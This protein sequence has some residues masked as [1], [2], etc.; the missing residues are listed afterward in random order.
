MKGKKS[1]F[2]V[3]SW[4][5]LVLGIFCGVALAGV[6]MK[7][8]PLIEENKIN[9]TRQLIPELL[10]GE[11]QARQAAAAG[12][13]LTS[14]QNMVPVDQGGGRTTS[15]NVFKATEADVVKGW[16]AKASGNGYAANIE[17]LVGLSPQADQITGL[18][19]LDQKET[20]GLG[21]KI[22]ERSWRG[23]F[24]GKNTG[25]AILAVKGGA[26]Q[27]YE[28]DAITGATISSKSVCSIINKTVADLKK[29][30][31]EQLAPGK[32]VQQ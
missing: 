6:E 10:L 14:T 27:P 8:S 31:A 26:D 13:T 16:V 15:Y 1:N 9:E 19:I 28:I 17:L 3:E 7:F 21:A 24:T 30:L 23:Q 12:Q 11:E 25:Q 20:P 4:L 22:A 32:T 18:F 29:P 2:I 5:V